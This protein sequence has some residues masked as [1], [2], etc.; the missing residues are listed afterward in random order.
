MRSRATDSWPIERPEPDCWGGEEYL[1][2]ASSWE[3]HKTYTASPAASREE[4]DQLDRQFMEHWFEATKGQRDRDDQSLQKLAHALGLPDTPHHDERGSKIAPEILNPLAVWEMLENSVPDI[5]MV[6]L[7]RVL[8][9]YADEPLPR[10]LHRLA[11]EAFAFSPT[12]DNGLPAT[13]RWAK[14]T[15]RP[16]VTLRACMRAASHAPAMIWDTSDDRFTPILPLASGYLPD[17]PIYGEVLQLPRCDGQ[18]LLARVYPV[19]DG[20]WQLYGAVWV[21]CPP[22]DT[23][24]SRLELEHLRLSRHE[25]RLTWEDLLRDRA[26]LLYRLCSI[27]SASLEA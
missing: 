6:A 1:Y 15:I 2:E 5:V 10:S 24:L 4:Y 11:T 12:I 18:T 25:R 26:E 21:H 7:D 20:S 27:Y 22:I 23:L 19:A 13:Q 16:S 9:P 8:G 3:N 17:G 14:D